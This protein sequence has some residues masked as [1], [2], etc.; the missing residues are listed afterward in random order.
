M[1][2]VEYLCVVD[3]GAVMAVNLLVFCGAMQGGFLLNC[4]LRNGAVLASQSAPEVHFPSASPAP[5]GSAKFPYVF[6][7]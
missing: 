4:I 7:H 3:V 1:E 5:F 2:A 6:S